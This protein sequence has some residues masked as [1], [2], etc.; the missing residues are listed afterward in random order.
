VLG[1][2]LMII[3]PVNGANID[4][5]DGVLLEQGHAADTCAVLVGHAI[6][7]RRFG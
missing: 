6:V 5:I 1:H 4:A 7:N 2:L 3:D